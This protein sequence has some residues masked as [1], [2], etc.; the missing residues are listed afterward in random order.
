MGPSKSSTRCRVPPMIWRRVRAGH[1]W[2]R[3]TVA[4]MLS[5]Q[6]CAWAE[7]AAGSGRVVSLLVVEHGGVLA[8]QVVHGHWLAVQADGVLGDRV[9]PE[10]RLGPVEDVELE[11]RRRAVHAHLRARAGK[12]IVVIPA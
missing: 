5:N 8:H 11:H 1:G 4:H 12:R 7:L 3:L 2:L 10:E 6:A 9:E